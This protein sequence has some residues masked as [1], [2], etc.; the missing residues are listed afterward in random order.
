MVVEDIKSVLYRNYW[1]NILESLTQ[2]VL[3]LARNGNTLQFIL[4]QLLFNQ[5]SNSAVSHSII[6][7]VF[8]FFFFFFWL[9]IISFKTTELTASSGQSKLDNIN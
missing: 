6:K 5:T 1:N 9:L 8:F 7:E 3:L 2:C 4:V